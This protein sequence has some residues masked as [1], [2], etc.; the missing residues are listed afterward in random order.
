MEAPPSIQPEKVSVERLLAIRAAN[1]DAFYV[2]MRKLTNKQLDELCRQDIRHKFCENKTTPPSGTLK[3]IRRA[4]E[5]ESLLESLIEEIA[6]NPS[7]SRALHRAVYI[8]DLAADSEYYDLI[9]LG[10]MLENSVEDM[11]K[12]S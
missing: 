3:Q 8:R 5:E 7:L 11:K 1:A 2:I 12:T 9:V 4:Y 10:D 6:E